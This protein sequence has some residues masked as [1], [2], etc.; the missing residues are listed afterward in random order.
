MF[1]VLDLFP[2]LW[3]DFSLEESATL[4]DGKYSQI[5]DLSGH[6]RHFS[7]ATAGN[8][9]ERLESGLNGRTVAR[10]NGISTFLQSSYTTPIATGFAFIVVVPRFNGLDVGSILSKRSYYAASTTDFPFD[11]NIS[12]TTPVR[13]NLVLD[14]G[15]NYTT[16]L[17]LSATG[18]AESTPLLIGAEWV[19]ASGGLARLYINGIF[20]S[21]DTSP[22]ISENS[23][24]WVLG[25]SSFEHGGGVGR[26]A[27]NGDIAE[28]IVAR[29]FPQID[30][31]QA[32]NDYLMEKWAISPGAIPLAGNVTKALGGP[33]DSVRV[34]DWETG[35]KRALVTP[36]ENG[37]WS[38]GLVSG[39][40]GVIYMANG[41]APVVHGPYTLEPE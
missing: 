21:S 15:G 27:L 18:F 19:G 9:P 23:R 1:D 5:N 38:V 8:R 16:D 24:P 32:C 3:V 14:S 41:C 25:R 26:T 20:K 33:A 4:V 22:N 2:S 30:L 7:Q 29:S 6:N 40:Y 28:V 31:Y 37:D 39:V 12:P 36:D 13:V 34:F 35:H 10:F 11:I 17:A